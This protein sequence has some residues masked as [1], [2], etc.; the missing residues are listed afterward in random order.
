[1]EGVLAALSMQKALS[2]FEQELM[3]TRGVSFGMRIGLNSGQ[4]VVG[5]IGTDLNPT[6]TAIGDAVNLASRIQSL[7]PVGSVAI[8]PNTERLVAGAFVTR[9]M[10]AHEVRGK[11]I[12]VVIHEVLGQVGRGHPLGSNEAPF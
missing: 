1:R 11:E 2:D 10:G 7:A 5:V 9:N 3:K 4:V 8:G 6:Y 12:P